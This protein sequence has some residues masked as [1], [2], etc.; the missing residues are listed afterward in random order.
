MSNK[1]RIDNL[2]RFSARHYFERPHRPP[3][4]HE[5]WLRDSWGNVI[6]Y[7]LAFIDHSLYSGDNG[8]VLGYDNAHGF[9]ERHFKGRSELIAFDSYERVSERFLDEVRRLRGN[10]SVDIEKS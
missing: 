5:H 9:H 4:I 3:L 10:T 8:R 1:R 7:G 6:R 2:T